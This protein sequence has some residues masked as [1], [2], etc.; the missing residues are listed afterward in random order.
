ILLAL[1]LATLFSQ[2]APADEPARSA[3][4]TQPA[5]YTK[6]EID[7]AIARGV[8]FLVKDQQPAG[9]WGTG[10]ETR[11]TEIYSSIPGSLDS[12]RIGASALCVMALREVGETK[13]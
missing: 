5:H 6:T 12:F 10:L 11:G 2:R 1:L 13:A 4:T 3:P 8:N 9:F 7:Q